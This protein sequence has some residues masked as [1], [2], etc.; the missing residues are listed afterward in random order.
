M[1]RLG[2]ISKE[3]SKPFVTLEGCGVPECPPGCQ[4]VTSIAE[5]AALLRERYPPRGGIQLLE[6]QHTHPDALDIDKIIV[7]DYMLDT[8]FVYQGNRVDC[9]RRIAQDIPS[10]FPI[11]PLAAQTLFSQL[12][13]LPKPPLQPVAYSAVIINLCKVR[14]PVE[15]RLSYSGRHWCR[16]V[17]MHGVCFRVD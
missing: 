15:L 1:H 17:M 5:R 16:R 4:E 2:M 6:P 14:R 7:E 3:V 12:L 9:V 13:L 10:P 11:Y 8:L